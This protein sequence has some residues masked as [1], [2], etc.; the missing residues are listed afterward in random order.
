MRQKTA[1]RRR[2]LLQKMFKNFMVTTCWINPFEMGPM[3]LYQGAVCSAFGPTENDC[4]S[5]GVYVAHI[6][7]NMVIGECASCNICESG[8]FEANCSNVGGGGQMNCD[9]DKVS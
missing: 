3:I 8:W 9:Y 1:L 5:C 6:G 7:T 2:L 4:S